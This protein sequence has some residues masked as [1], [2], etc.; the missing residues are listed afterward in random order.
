MVKNRVLGKGLSALIQGAEIGIASAGGREIREIPVAE[1]SFNPDQPR[2]IFKQD[3]LEE[4]A[5]SLRDVG[6]LQPILVRRL[7]EGERVPP[8]EAGAPL[9]RYVVVAGERRVRAAR[10]AGLNDVPA[11]TCSYEEAE[12]LRIS[13][14][15][16][17]QRENLGPIEEAVAYH[18]LLDA[19]GATQ[20]ELADMLGKNRSTVA[21]ALRLLTLEEEIRQ[22]VED[23]TLTRGHAKALLALPPGPERLRL[24]RLCRSR[25]L[26]VREVE[27]RA[28]GAAAARRRARR[29]RAAPPGG[30]RETPEIRALRERAEAHFGS[31]VEIERAASGKGRVAVTFYDDAD[32]ERLLAMMGLSTDLD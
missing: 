8:V 7:R 23:G 10:L 19:Y 2:K 12:A 1:L 17:I 15:E 31:P 27:R 28:Q 21:N 30:S 24:A 20:E 13:L 3:K 26:S 18:G 4:L 9:P 22:L 6:V 11:V 14:L 32:L 16:N 25:G 29:K 5:A